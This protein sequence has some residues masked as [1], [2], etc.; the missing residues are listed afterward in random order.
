MSTKDDNSTNLEHLYKLERTCSFKIIDARDA[1]IAYLREYVQE[2]DQRSLASESI[3]KVKE[4]ENQFNQIVSKLNHWRRRLEY[5]ADIKKYG[6][7]LKEEEAELDD[8]R[9]YG[10]D[11]EYYRVIST[12]IDPMRRRLEYLME[13]KADKIK[14]SR[15]EQAELGFL[16]GLGV[17]SGDFSEL[18][19]KEDK[20][21]ADADLKTKVCPAGGRF[22]YDIDS[23]EEC[24]D[25]RVRADCLRRADEVEV[26]FIT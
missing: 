22:G 18:N 24:C 14:L 7:S 10:A 11:W 2:M 15:Y 21:M 1:A 12:R 5:L 26:K 23:L 9:N 13:K 25:C 3:E 8:L 20:V 6:W 4:I 19:L 17:D 16:K